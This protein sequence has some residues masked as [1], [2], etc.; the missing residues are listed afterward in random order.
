MT[1]VAY[2]PLYH[3]VLRW[4]IDL[5]GNSTAATRALSA[6]FSLGAIYDLFDICRLLHRPGTA[7]VAA[8]LMALSPAQL[9]FAQQ[10]RSYAMLI[11]LALACAD[12]LV[13]IELRG[14]TPRRL[15]LLAL[16]AAA[17][18]LTHYFAI[19][20]LIGTGNLCADPL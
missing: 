15:A 6:V 13:R 20:A 14:A 9:D 12:V 5:F 8:A 11:L 4:W 3:I 7:L 17:T 19:G 16:L 18:M 2:P 1:G 10:T